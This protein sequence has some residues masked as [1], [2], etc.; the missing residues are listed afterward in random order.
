MRSGDLASKNPNSFP[1]DLRQFVNDETWVFAKT[2]AEIWPHEYLARER[3]DGQLFV[4]LI[5]HIR[6]NGYRAQSRLPPQPC[7]FGDRDLSTPTLEVHECGGT[8]TRD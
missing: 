1:A 8:H 2:Y 3:V 5:E 4:K 6:E 7:F